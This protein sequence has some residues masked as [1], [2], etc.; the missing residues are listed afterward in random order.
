[1]LSEMARARV[2]SASLATLIALVLALFV[3]YIDYLSGTELNVE[4]LYF[5]PVSVA[6]WHAGVTSAAVLS[7]VSA[8]AW[9]IANEAAGLS[10]SRP[11]LWLGNM[12]TQL[13]VFAVVGLLI[14][15]LRQRVEQEE[16]SSRHDELTGLPNARAFH[17]R[18]ELELARAR[19]YG[20][21][22]TLAY[23]DLDNFKAINDH[24]GHKAG[25]SVLR[26]AASILRRSAR[27]SDLPARLGGDEFVVLMP[28]TGAEG[29]RALLERVRSE[30]ESAISSTLA[31]VSASIGAASFVELP[32]SVDQLLGAADARMYEVKRAGKNLVRVDELKPCAR[33]G[34]A[35]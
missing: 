9:K 28:E 14:A 20:G 10:Y 26:T 27:A 5:L 11:E 30:V 18:A 15:Y 4:P 2:R 19:R 29:A 12:A 22:L 17:E 31:P 25:D 13:V 35:V 24:Y 1:M 8:T 23:I 6:A 21:P 7:A 34:N 33:S 32:D 3:A 16:W